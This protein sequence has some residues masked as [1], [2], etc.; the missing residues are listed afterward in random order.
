MDNN[1]SVIWLWHSSRYNVQVLFLT[2]GIQILF[3]F[4]NSCTKYPLW[5]SSNFILGWNV[6]RETHYVKLDT[7]YQRKPGVALS[8]WSW[9][10]LFWAQSP[11]MVAFFFATSAQ[12]ISR[13]NYIYL[14][15]V[16]FGNSNTK[17][18]WCKPSVKFMLYI[19]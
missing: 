15:T 9:W 14:L 17:N 10:L 7:F 3:Y 1:S 19:V 11:V 8:A 12:M 18:L 4:A 6:N 5:S 13:H 16:S 2:C